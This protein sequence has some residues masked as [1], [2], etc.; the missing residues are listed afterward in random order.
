[1]NEDL[2]F[3]TFLFISSKKFVISVQTDLNKKIFEKELTLNHNEK[4]L[5][6]D[7]LDIFLNENIFE[8]EKILKYFVKKLSVVLDLD[9]FLPVEISIK[10]SNYENVINLSALNH[11]LNEIKDY[12][13]ETIGE[14]RIVHM[15]ISN[16]K[17]DNKNFSSLPLDIYCKSFSLDVNFL[18]ISESLIKMIEIILKKYQISLSNILSAKYI[19]E[20]LKNEKIDFFIM[21]KKIVEG[22]NPNEVLM[23][24]KINKNKGFFEKF[25]NFFN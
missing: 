5:I 19:N 25:F 23:V 8:I 3:E 22:H 11:M 21:T 17:I 7:K 9:E 18:C 16:N 15:F 2:N 10:K 6:F 1:M 20:F 13:K 4:Y 24:N 14:R 12:C